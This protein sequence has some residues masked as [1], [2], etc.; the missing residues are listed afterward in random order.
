MKEANGVHGMAK[1]AASRSGSKYV[2]CTEGWKGMVVNN[3]MYGCGVFVWSQN[4][5]NDFKVEQNEMGKCICDV[6]KVK[7]E[8]I[9]GET[10]WSSF[11][12][13]EAKAMVS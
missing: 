4:E 2:I 7:N 8:C 6:V 9:S 5:C 12:E 3:L 13:R 1:F 10:G 11:E